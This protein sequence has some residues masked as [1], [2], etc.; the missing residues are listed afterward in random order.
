MTRFASVQAFV[1]QPFFDAAP[2]AL[3]KLERL[4]EQAGLAGGVVSHPSGVMSLRAAE[5][6]MVRLDQYIKH[7]TY[8][9]DALNG[10]TGSSDDSVA[11]IALPRTQT[12]VEAVD[13]IAQQIS[14]ILYGAAFL[15]QRQGNRLW[16][17]RT[18]GTTDF[19]NHWPVQQYNIAVAVQSV[20]K[21]IGRAVLPCALRLSHHVP[22]AFMPEDWRDLPVDLSTRTMGVAFH[23]DDLMPHKDSY[24]I[25]DPTQGP[26]S[27][28]QDTDVPALRACLETYLG[29]TNP[30]CLSDK[31]ARAF[32]MSTR[33]YRRHLTGLGLTHRQMVS[34][35]RLSKAQELL[36]DPSITITEIAFE[37][38]YVHSSA[39]TRF[40]KAR[41]CRTPQEFRLS[42][43]N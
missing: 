43:L 2:L 33:S 29:T 9:I 19:T 26:S 25:N 21:V 12:G 16:L 30:E 31:M 36:V 4:A 10:A 11:N 22:K 27:S 37:L 1:A 20:Q 32:G 7:P 6:F 39:F 28:V 40:F 5:L 35:A 24:V 41:T 17:L 15:T 3:T 42:V 34:D 38:G 13:A 23:L 8:F 18:A 14:S